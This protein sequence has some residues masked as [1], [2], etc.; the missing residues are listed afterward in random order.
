M[1]GDL[2]TELDIAEFF[3]YHLSDNSLLTVATFKRSVNVDF[4]VIDVENESNTAMGFREKPNYN[5]NVSMGV[6][7]LNRKLLDYIPA[8]RPFGFDNLMLKLLDLQLPVKV[9]K[10]SGYWLDIGR[11]VDY[12]KANN[13]I[14]KFNLDKSDSVDFC[15]TTPS[16]AIA[17]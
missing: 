8:D 15:Q 2:L 3:N 6:Y 1:N 12:E 9:Y 13:D 4:G 7:G 14:D 11:P 10:Y 17:S 16:A 5:F